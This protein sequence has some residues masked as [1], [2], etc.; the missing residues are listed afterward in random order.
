MFVGRKEAF[1]LH[2]SLVFEYILGSSLCGV[3][4]F[5]SRYV[6][7]VDGRQWGAYSR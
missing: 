1:A 3:D 5:S 7:A 6:A 4:Y 2:H